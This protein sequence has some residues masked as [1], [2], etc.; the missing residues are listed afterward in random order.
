MQELIN[1]LSDAF[2]S[3]Y[4]QS[5]PDKDSI[6]VVGCST[7][8]VL[9][10]KIGKAGSLEVA[11]VIFKTLKEKADKHG[12][13]LAC[14]CCEHLN[15]AIVIE[16]SVAKQNGFTIVNAVP[17]EHA[18]GSFATAAYKGFE[19][20]VLVESVRAHL[21]IDIGLTLIGMHLE[22]V[23]VPVRTSVTKIG[24]ATVVFARSRHKYIG[25]PRT[26]YE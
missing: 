21:G 10:E 24:K 18:G 11:Q 22:P 4:E 12:L 23:A 20:P 9:G 17:Y 19:N 16:K 13:F 7:S 26:K 8:E 14:Q 15:R 1:Q 6:L 2:D 25:G 5:K 3:L